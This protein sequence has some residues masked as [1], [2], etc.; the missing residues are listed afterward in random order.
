MMPFALALMGLEIWY[1][2]KLL[3][4]VRSRAAQ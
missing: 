3:I 2:N 1:M 4:Y